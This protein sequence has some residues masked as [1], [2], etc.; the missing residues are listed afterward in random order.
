LNYA[1]SVRKRT[2]YTE[3]SDVPHRPAIKWCCRRQHPSNGVNNPVCWRR[4]R[5]HL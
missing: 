5:K 2:D 3:L 4:T 1:R